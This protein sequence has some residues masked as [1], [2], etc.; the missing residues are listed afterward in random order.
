MEEER[1][2]TSK[3]E[4]IALCVM[5]L[6]GIG[7]MAWLLMH[8]QKVA[9]PAQPAKPTPPSK[10]Q[11]AFFAGG[12][13]KPTSIVSTGQAGDTRLFVLGQ[14]GLIRIVNTD[15][16]VVD[17]PFLDLT[18]TVLPGAETGLLGLAFSPHYD[19]DGFFYIDYVDKSLTTVI[20]RYHVTSDP[21]KADKTSAQVVL[22]QKQPYPNHKGGALVF[23]ADGYLYI[24][25]GDGGSGGDPENRAQNLQTWLGKIL[26]LDV[27]TLPYKIP[28]DNPFATQA[29]AKPEIWDYGLRNPWRISFDHKT[30]QLYIAD[31]GQGDI[32]EINVEAAKKGGNNYG[33]RCFE[34]TKDFKLDGCK[35]RDQYVFPVLDYDHSDGRCSI[36][37]GYVYRGDKYPGL[38]GKYFY[39]DYCGGQLYQ[40]ANQDNKWNATLIGKT[41]YKISTFGEDNAGELYVADYQT[42]SIYRLQAVAD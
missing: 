11:L 8:Q 38:D 40:L 3:A 12:L 33:W 29:G 39:G 42:G 21:N 5:L 15:G 26:R 36:T 22:T 17:Q 27:A 23:G 10:V 9:T 28:A 30:Q 34:G 16:T 37:G 24:A 25:F 19:K 6:L 4:I 2:G 41:P 35:A 32:E 13:P 18:D 7:V 1:S 20:A 14:D 31:V